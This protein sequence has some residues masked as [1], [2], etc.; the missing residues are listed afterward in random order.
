MDGEASAVSPQLLPWPTSPLPLPR[1]FGGWVTGDEVRAGFSAP[2]MD[3]GGSR[4]RRRVAVRKRNRPSL[5]SIFAASTAAELQ[6]GDEE[7]EEEEMMAGSRRKK[8]AEVQPVEVQP[9][10]LSNPLSSLSRPL[11]ER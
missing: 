3:E 6:P 1:G 9:P 10:Q 8:T 11:L 4:I 7:E 5:E 2:A